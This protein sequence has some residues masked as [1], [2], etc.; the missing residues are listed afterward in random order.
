MLFSLRNQHFR[1]HNS[2]YKKMFKEFLRIM[3]SQLTSIL[4][5]CWIFQVMIRMTIGVILCHL[6]LQAGRLLIRVEDA[7]SKTANR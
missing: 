1:F 4:A 7:V 5:I 6:S 3:I 2:D